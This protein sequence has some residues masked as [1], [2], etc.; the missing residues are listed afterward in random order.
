MADQ[1]AGFGAGVGPMGQAVSMISDRLQAIGDAIT[2][3]LDDAAAAPGRLGE[4]G[5]LL[6]GDGALG[7]VGWVLGAAAGA[8][9]A[10]L[11]LAMVARRLLRPARL[12]FSQA[13]PDTAERTAT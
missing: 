3:M 8:I 10:A 11:V 2:A 7:S 4:A 13:A 6:T 1:V 5:R 12:R 9:G